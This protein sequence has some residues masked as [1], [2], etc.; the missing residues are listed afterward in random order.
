MTATLGPAGVPAASRGHRKRAAQGYRKLGRPGQACSEGCSALV[1]QSGEV[2]G[3]ND[4]FHRSGVPIAG[5]VGDGGSVHDC[6]VPSPKALSRA[7]SFVDRSL[8][9]LRTRL[10]RVAFS[11]ASLV[12][13]VLSTEARGL[14]A[15]G[16]TC[17]SDLC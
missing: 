9:P 5:Q 15:A 14:N 1:C 3:V 2:L 16:F 11:A 4:R 7:R 12:R 6:D 13:P 8:K 10:V 17:L